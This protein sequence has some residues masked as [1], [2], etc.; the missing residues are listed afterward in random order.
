MHR[1]A[2]EDFTEPVSNPV[3][4]RVSEQIADSSIQYFTRWVSLFLSFHMQ[5]SLIQIERAVASRQ[6]H[7]YFWRMSSLKR[8]N[9]GE[10]AL[11]ARLLF[12]EDCSQ[13]KS[14]HHHH[15]SDVCVPCCSFRGSFCCFELIPS[16]P[17]PTQA[18]LRARLL[19]AFAQSDSVIIST[20]DGRWALSY[21]TVTTVLTGDN[22]PSFQSHSEL[23]LLSDTS[24][25]DMRVWLFV[26]ASTFSLPYHHSPLHQLFRIDKYKSI[27]TSL[28]AVNNLVMFTAHIQ[29]SSP[30]APSQDTFFS[31]RGVD[32]NQNNAQMTYPALKRL[33]EILIEGKPP[34]L[35]SRYHTMDALLND[36]STSNPLL[37]VVR[38]L[39]SQCNPDQQ[40]AI[41][42]CFN[43]ED[44]AIVQ[45][46]PGTG[47]TTI[48][49]IIVLISV[50]QNQH[51]L[52][53]SHTHTAID[54]V[55]IKLL[56]YRLLFTIFSFLDLPILRIGDYSRLHPSVR[57]FH[58][59]QRWSGS[60]DEYVSIMNDSLIVGATVYTSV[61]Q[62]PRGV[63]F[64]RCIIDEAGQITEPSTLQVMLLSHKTLLVGDSMQL[65]PLV[66]S[67]S[68]IDGGLSVSLL[69]RLE[70]AFPQCASRLCIQYRMNKGIMALTNHLIYNHCLASAS[71]QLDSSVLTLSL[72]PSVPKWVATTLLPQHSVVFVNTDSCWGGTNH[73]TISA[74]SSS[75]QNAFEANIVETLLTQMVQG[76]MECADIGVISPYSAQVAF[77][78]TCLRKYCKL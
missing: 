13:F 65:P 24:S 45:G 68:L 74:I 43:S 64:D 75:H 42:H 73:E 44:V 23:P 19:T 56:P 8:Q 36:C 61:T 41:L 25:S 63:V 69:S 37:K 20:G 55:L 60:F 28:I 22:L 32:L 17:S 33:R 50:L 46:L 38:E 14:H 29:A 66:Q 76:G 27:D 77:L 4:Q 16:S 31:Q 21:A 53:S 67:S 39:V 5:F 59:S 30:T 47:K 34:R 78:S 12:M 7:D 57:Q 71:A 9:D 11:Q 3:I 6:N 54:N 1:N 58:L 48:I 72:S 10:T 49:T 62:F 35:S 15:F 26:S 52:L 2:S 51:V 70:K 40:A 18:S